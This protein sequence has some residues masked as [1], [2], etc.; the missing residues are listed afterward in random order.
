M[1]VRT[2]T[3]SDAADL[4]ELNRLF[5]NDTTVELIKK[6]LTENDREVVCT[7]FVAGV[8]AGYCSGLIVKSM[9]YRENRADIESLYVKEEY[10]KLGVGAALIKCLEE[11][12]AS[13]GISHFHI[14]TSLDNI[15]AQALYA[16]LGYREAGEMLLD[17][18]IAV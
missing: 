16:K 8:A 10:R 14:N 12:L 13:L 5:D 1:E 6:S 2:A 11:R 4:F 15:K 7:A 3:I 9:C 17:K 18:T